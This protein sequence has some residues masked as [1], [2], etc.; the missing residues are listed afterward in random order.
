MAEGIDR[1][2]H[3]RI[4]PGLGLDRIHRDQRLFRV[5]FDIDELLGHP[6]ATLAVGDGVVQLLDHGG[7]SALHSLDDRELPERTRAVEGPVGQVAGEIEHV[8]MGS[9]A[10]DPELAEV[11]AEVELGILS[12]L[13]RREPPERRHDPLPESGDAHRR[14]FEP[15]S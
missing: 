12:P 5:S 6:D 1:P 13:R 2:F 15:R 11:V 7:S 10:G 14:G 4:R 8:S 3:D 9:F